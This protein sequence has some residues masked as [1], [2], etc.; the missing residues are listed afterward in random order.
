MI[1]FVPGDVVILKAFFV[2]SSKTKV[3]NES[4]HRTRADRGVGI[5]KKRILGPKGFK[6]QNMYIHSVFKSKKKSQFKIF[7]SKSSNLF[8]FNLTN[9]L[10][11]FYE[12]LQSFEHHIFE[13][14]RQNLK[15][16]T[17]WLS[18][19]RRL[20]C[21]LSFVEMHFLFGWPIWSTLLPSKTLTNGSKIVH[22]SFYALPKTDKCRS[23]FWFWT[24][25]F[26]VT[27]KA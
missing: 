3:E 14:L 2:L 18:I 16:V 20:Y 24:F 15:S 27:T 5:R 21:C 19:Y 22:K 9:F 12:L 1:I 10:R 11:K 26:C 8:P 23:G 25:A 17:S 4:Q 7:V 6:T 13:F